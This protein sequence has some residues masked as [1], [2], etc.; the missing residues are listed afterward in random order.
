MIRRKGKVK[1]FVAG[2]THA[3]DGNAQTSMPSPLAHW[4]ITERYVRLLK[5]LVP[6]DPYG[7]TY[8]DVM[9]ESVVLRAINGDPRA[10]KEVVRMYPY[11]AEF[12]NT[13]LAECQAKRPYK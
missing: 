8:L 7:R 3:M 1:P 4:P 11:R 9:V 6:G 12:L 2:G 5:R 10:F 13:F